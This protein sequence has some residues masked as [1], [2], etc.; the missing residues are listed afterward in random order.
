M[1]RD[2]LKNGPLIS[3]RR[4]KLWARGRNRNRPPLR[5]PSENRSIV[6]MDSSID[7]MLSWVWI[8]AF[9]GPVVPEV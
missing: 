5:T 3:M 1:I 6:S 2:E 7:S 8:T 9:W 4:P